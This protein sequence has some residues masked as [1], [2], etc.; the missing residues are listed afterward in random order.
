MKINR[1]NGVNFTIVGYSDA[2]Y[3]NDKDT[4]NSITGIIICLCGVPIAWRSRAQKCL[5]LSTTENKYYT[6][7]ELRS[8]IIFI[9]NTLEFL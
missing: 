3:G 5:T 9:K 4:R 8:E 6:M 1:L 2:D 7:L